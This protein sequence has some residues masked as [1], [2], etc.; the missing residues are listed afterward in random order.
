LTCANRRPYSGAGM[1]HAARARGVG[2]L[3]L[4]R[5]GKEMVAF[6]LPLASD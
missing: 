3:L 4:A 6:R 5:N 1:R 2:H